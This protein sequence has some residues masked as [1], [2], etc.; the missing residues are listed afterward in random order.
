[1]VLADRNGVILRTLCNADAEDLFRECYLVPS[2]RIVFITDGHE[3]PPIH[4]DFRRPARSPV[5]ENPGVIVGVGGDTPRPIPQLND[6][7]VKTGYWHAEDVEQVDIYTAAVQA[8][9][10]I[11][12]VG[13]NP[14]YTG[15]EHLSRLK[16]KYLREMAEEGE[17]IYH[18]FVDPAE[19]TAVLRRADLGTPVRSL[20]DIRPYLLMPALALFV[21]GYCVEI[22]RHRWR[23]P[24]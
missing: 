15:N 19:F 23:V 2:P 11:A 20:H 21:A 14:L 13:P 6:E 18:H 22:I 12:G 3:A 24:T 16:G 9:K 17:L 10:S 5:T 4:P 7:G 1:M 8:G